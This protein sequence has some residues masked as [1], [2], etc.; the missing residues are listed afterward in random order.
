MATFKAYTYI[1]N[2][3]KTNKATFVIQKVQPGLPGLMN[4]A[5]STPAPIFA[6]AGFNAPANKNNQWQL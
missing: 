5:E 2:M 3:G 6:T 1:Q 4:G